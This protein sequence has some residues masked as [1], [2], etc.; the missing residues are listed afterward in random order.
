MRDPKTIRKALRAAQSVLRGSR[1][2]VA[3]AAA[4]LALVSAPGC[5]KQTGTVKDAGAQADASAKDLLADIQDIIN[6]KLAPE[7][8]VG[9]Q[10]I[11]NDA[12]AAEVL[13]ETT[14]Q[15]ASVDVASADGTQADGSAPCIITCFQPTNTLCESYKDCEITEEIPGTCSGSGQDCVPAKPCDES[16]SCD[17]YQGEIY[18]DVDQDGNAAPW[19]P[20]ACLD[21]FCHEGMALSMAA[22]ECCGTAWD[23]LCPGVNNPTGCI[24]WGPPA[25]PAFEVA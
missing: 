10:D 20:I 2:G 25:P 23:N 7:V 24:A 17:G 16:E 14:A 19:S 18:A 11:I 8:V 15:D 1:R 3:T 21:G 4:G 5:L 9:L 13:S 22:A 12:G 6:D